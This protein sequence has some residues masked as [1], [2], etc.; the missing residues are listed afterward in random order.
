M[1]SV[2]AAAFNK[3]ANPVLIEWSSPA[4]PH[5]GFDVLVCLGRKERPQ[6]VLNFIPSG[7]VAT[8]G[9]AGASVGKPQSHGSSKQR[10]S[11]VGQETV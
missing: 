5:L 9:K 3:A 1:F 8:I 4:L 6:L 2:C 7:I 10:K 11:V